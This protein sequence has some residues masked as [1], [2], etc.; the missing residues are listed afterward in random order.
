MKKQ[1]VILALA[2]V[3]LAFGDGVLGYTGGKLAKTAREG[4]HPD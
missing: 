4:A 3:T 1:N 2:V